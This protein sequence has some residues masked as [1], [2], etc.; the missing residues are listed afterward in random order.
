[1]LGLA[2]FLGVLLAWGITGEV[3]WWLSAESGVLDRGL[4]GALFAIEVLLVL[5][6]MALLLTLL[7]SRP[8][9][10]RALEVVPR[11]DVLVPVRNED[12]SVLEATL[13]A[14]GQLRGHSGRVLVLDDSEDVARRQANENL[15]RRYGVEHHVRAVR[16]GYKAGAMNH[17]LALTDAPFVAILDVDHAPE[18]DFLLQATAGFALPRVACVQT[19]I[20]WRNAESGIRRLA[21]MLQDQFYGVVQWDRASRGAAVFAGSAAVFR[22]AA[23][24]DVG[25]F[26]EETLVEDFDLTILLQAR[27][28][29]IHYDD[30]TGARGLLPWTGRD[31]ARQLW[32]WSHGTTRV[33][34]LRAGTIVRAPIPWRQRAELLMGAASYL[35]GGLFVAV[36]ALLA[37]RAYGGMAAPMGVWVPLA[38]LAPACILVSH[39]VTAAVAARRAARPVGLASL[40][41][42]HAV[43]LAYTPVLFFSTL[44]ALVS[45]RVHDEGR[46][47]KTTQTAGHRDG[48]LAGVSVVTGL[49]G[50]L[51]VAVALVEAFTLLDVWIFELGLAFLLPALLWTNAS[52]R[53]PHVGQLVSGDA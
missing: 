6:S 13:V 5:F 49:L 1:M 39:V 23:L 27:Q 38:I 17:G 22:R 25:G 10:P 41:G 28:W 12:A 52:S 2:A 7:A 51:L 48:I 21:A 36:G 45:G 46:V 3:A 30:R 50:A 31:I 35:V 15:A 19:R 14:I 32:R 42:Y 20:G 26:P 43:T 4:G 34:L 53:R 29:R 11:V 9:A 37:A 16:A 24:D 18:P 33:L 40:L 8:P 44:F 47:V